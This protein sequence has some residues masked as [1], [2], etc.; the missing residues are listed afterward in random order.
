MDDAHNGITRRNRKC[1]CQF[2]QLSISMI[3]C[4]EEEEWFNAMT[5]ENVCLRF[6]RNAGK[7]CCYKN[8]VVFVVET[9]VLSKFYVLLCA[10]VQCDSDYYVF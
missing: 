10:S 5:S 2:L 9:I 1:Q 7:M 4:K 6:S 3:L 8:S